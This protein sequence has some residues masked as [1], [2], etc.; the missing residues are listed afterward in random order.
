[1]V[2]IS[3]V[4]MA[5]L[6]ACDA[7]LLTVLICVTMSFY[8]KHYLTNSDRGRV[9]VIVESWCY[10]SDLL[11]MIRTSVGTPHQEPQTIEAAVLLESRYYL[12]PAKL[13]RIGKSR[14]PEGI[15]YNNDRVYVDV[16]GKIWR[17]AG[18]EQS[19]RERMEPLRDS[20]IPWG[21]MG[22]MN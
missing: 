7:I 12:E 9:G 19:R 17:T 1:M 21:Y 10:T 3:S 16:S 18:T 8:R 4:W 2:S 5:L 13:V 6:I 22:E 15:L 11:D 20:P 14:I